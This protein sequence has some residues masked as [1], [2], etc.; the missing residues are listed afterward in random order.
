[1]AQERDEAR[2]GEAR[3]RLELENLRA[4]MAD[5]AEFEA[6]KKSRGRESIVAGV[7]AT[8]NETPYDTLILDMG[9]DEGVVAGA[10]VYAEG[11]RPIGTI[12]RTT[13]STAIAT[14]FT[15]PGITT[16]VY[17]V[18]ER[19]LARAV[20]MGGGSLSVFL[21]H[22]SEPR[23]GDSMLMPTLGGVPIGTVARVW[24]EPSEPGVIAAVTSPISLASLRMV[25]IDT[26]AFTM[27]S[28]DDI[29]AHIA[30]FTSLQASS[31]N[32]LFTIPDGTL[33]DTPTTSSDRV[34]S[35]SSQRL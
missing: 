24:S 18:R 35:T 15:S 1:V 10:V 30:E 26:H 4:A 29:R 25:S 21:P 7:L 17:A 20:G 16:H 31:T 12:T 27:P 32:M 5:T 23:E 6:L 11:G 34:N 19:V 28:T 13:A 9:S 22:G 2:A 14:L 8:P 3:A 33:F